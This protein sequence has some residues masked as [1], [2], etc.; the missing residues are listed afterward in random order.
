MVEFVIRKCILSCYLAQEIELQIRFPL[1]F[2]VCRHLAIIAV[3]QS[4]APTKLGRTI[5][6]IFTQ[7]LQVLHLK[8]CKIGSKI[9]KSLDKN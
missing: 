2:Y 5:G 3:L 4:S 1:G 8:T 6:S 7:I 9:E